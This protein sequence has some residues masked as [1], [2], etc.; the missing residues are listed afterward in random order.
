MKRM[1]KILIS[2]VM[3]DNM[4]YTYFPYLHTRSYVCNNLFGIIFVYLGCT[5]NTINYY[6]II[7][8][9]MIAEI[10]EIFFLRTTHTFVAD[11]SRN[12]NYID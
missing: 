4:K 9:S 5:M 10:L 3:L 7:F 6:F 2:I 12:T 11:Q 1:F 8:S